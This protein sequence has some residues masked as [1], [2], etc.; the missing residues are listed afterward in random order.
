MMAGDLPCFEG[1]VLI[2]ISAMSRERVIGQGEGMPW[3][4]PAEFDQFLG[5]IR[6]QTVIMGRRSWEIFG[7]DLT[8]R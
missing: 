7:A 3:D 1:V 5:F 4:V 6:D 8:S 2:V